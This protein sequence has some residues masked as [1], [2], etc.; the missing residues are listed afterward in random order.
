MSPTAPDPTSGQAPRTG[1]NRPV[2]PVAR[3]A[4]AVLALVVGGAVSLNLVA[5]AF[6]AWLPCRSA[7]TPCYHRRPSAAL[8]ISLLAVIAVALSALSIRYCIKDRVVHAI[9]ALLPL[10]ALYLVLPAL[11]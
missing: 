5:L 1:L 11:G 2:H 8:A 10:V 6:G 9:A 4:L 7:L 3:L